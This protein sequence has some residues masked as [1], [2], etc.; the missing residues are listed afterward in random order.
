MLIGKLGR[1]LSKPDCWFWIS[2]WV[3]LVDE[4]DLVVVLNGRRMETQE[5]GASISCVE[6]ACWDDSRRKFWKL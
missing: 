6:V 3:I 1:D 4:V 5:V 2:K